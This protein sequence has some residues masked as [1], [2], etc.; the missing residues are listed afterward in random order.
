MKILNCA[1]NKLSLRWLDTELLIYNDFCLC[2]RSHMLGSISWMVIYSM[3]FL[4]L[5]ISTFRM[6]SQNI[7]YTT[8]SSIWSNLIRGFVCFTWRLNRKFMPWRC[9]LLWDFTS[10]INWL[11]ILVF[12]RCCRWSCGSLLLHCQLLNIILI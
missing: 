12:L 3:R 8:L 6:P 7:I 9:E 10:I 4:Y 5:Y 2:I 1:L 11:R